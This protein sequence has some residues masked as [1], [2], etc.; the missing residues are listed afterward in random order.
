LTWKTSS[1][2][3]TT[4]ASGWRLSAACRCGKRTRISPIRK[5][6]TA[7]ASQLSLHIKFPDGS[8]KRPDISFFCQ[9][10]T[11]TETAVTDVPEAVVEIVSRGYE[12][13]DLELGPP[14]YL[15]Q[16]VKDVIVFDPYDKQVLHFDAAGK[17]EYPSPV[18]LELKCGCQLTA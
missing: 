6:L 16:G 13:K 1:S 15:G 18:A 10:P 5:R 8:N 17:R 14:F 4:S 12:A 2:A 9:R 3:R 7:S 11:E